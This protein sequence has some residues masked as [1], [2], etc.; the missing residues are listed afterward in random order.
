EQ[1]FV[2]VGVDEDALPSIGRRLSA[3]VHFKV[4]LSA[5]DRAALMSRDTD[6]FNRWE[7]G[8]AL[9][10]DV[11]L[12]MAETAKSG[13][14]PR[15]DAIYVDAIGEVLARAEED[16]AFAAEMLAPP[17]ESELALKMTPAD[18]VAIHD[19]RMAL[20]RGV[21][22]KHRESFG[23]LYGKLESA[24]AFAPDAASAGRRRLRNAC[25]RYLT[26]EDTDASA[27]IAEA[28]YR[29]ASNMTDM[30]AGLAALSRMDWPERETA[31][32]D[33]HDRFAKDPLVLDKWM[34]LQ[35]GSPLATTMVQVRALMKHPAFD[36]QNP[37]RVRA[38]IGAFSAN[39]LRFHEADGS[40]YALVCDVLRELDSINPQVAAR[41]AAA[42]ENWRRY[43]DARQQSM[44]AELETI[45]KKPGLSANLFEVASKILK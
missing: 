16:H 3:P 23:A 41:M 10:T 20:I 30:I 40:G 27:Q 4:S 15:A 1:R 29:S 43:D 26:A 12:E 28:H 22:G 8:Q 7:A 32:A 35:A 19:A 5:V 36:I 18:P 45:L 31:F 38:L 34:A 2:F 9:A 6:P 37:N 11:L 33:F 24:Q 21:A 14:A 42:F 25:L 13:I 39:H 44:R 17:G